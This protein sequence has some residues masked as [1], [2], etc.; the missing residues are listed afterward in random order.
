MNERELAK[1]LNYSHPKELYVVDWRNKLLLL[2]C[3]IKAMVKND[4]GHL[5]GNEVV[6]IE[7]IKVTLELITVFVIEG[8][9]YY[10]YHFEIIID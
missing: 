9:A 7:E 8:F 1:I 4:I 10:Y 5:K 6:L 3:P 2:R